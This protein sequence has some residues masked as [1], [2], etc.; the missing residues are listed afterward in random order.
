MRI[1]ADE[2]WEDHSVDCP[3]CKEPVK[4]ER[5]HFNPDTAIDPGYWECDFVEEM[6]EGEVA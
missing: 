1:P 4:S 3:C 2:H 5:Q 6:D